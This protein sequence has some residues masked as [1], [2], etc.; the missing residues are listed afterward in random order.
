[1]SSR[2]G[3]ALV[4][5]RWF[6]LVLFLSALS[7]GEYGM[8]VPKNPGSVAVLVTDESGKSI[9]DVSVTVSAV[10]SSGGTYYVGRRTGAD[11]RVTIPSIPAGQRE[12]R[13]TPPAAYAEGADPLSRQVEVI[14]GRT[15]SVVFRLR[16]L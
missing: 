2:I 10:N 16:R 6:L 9:A 1:M 4:D 15:V 11:G 13:I 7:C 5:G 12:V 8:A 14:K 3:R